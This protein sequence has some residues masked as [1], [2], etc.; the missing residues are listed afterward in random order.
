MPAVI[1]D[2]DLA[3]LLLKRGIVRKCAAALPL[4][5]ANRAPTF[6]DSHHH[7]DTQAGAKSKMW[8][9]ARTMG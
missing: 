9:E 2:N 5:H 6:F 8:P 3:Q 1:H 7:S 4:V